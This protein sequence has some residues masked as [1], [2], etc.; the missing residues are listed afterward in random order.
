MPK[1]TLIVPML[2]E[3]PFIGACLTSITAQDYQGGLEVLVYD[4][5]ST[6][7]SRDIVARIA[8][9]HPGITL[10]DNPRRIQAAAWNLG[11]ERATGDIIGIVGAH[12]ELASD[13][14]RMAVDTLDRTRADMV[15]GPVRADSDGVVGEAVALA[16]STPFGVG[17][18]RFHYTEVEEEV[19]TV[20]MGLCRAEVY[21]SLLFDEEMVRNQDDELSYRLLDRGGRIVCNPAIQSRYRNRATWRGLARQYYEYGFWKVAVMRKHPRQVRPRH[22]IPAALVS[23]AGGSAAIAALWPPGRW[24]LASVIAAYAAANL[25]ASF[26]ATR[27]NL[28]RL[29]AV[30][31]VYATLHLAYGT[32]TIAGLVREARRRLSS[33]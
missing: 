33:R 2:D 15:G 6:D 27:G 1:V 30:S 25:G 11:I 23:A 16:T 21:R 17:G 32:G 29:P 12:S 5:G 10:L 28:G 20:Y 26:V 9:A 22:L 18:A 24:A 14:V 13:Y 19:D 31:A 7:D 8:A 4:G 3:A